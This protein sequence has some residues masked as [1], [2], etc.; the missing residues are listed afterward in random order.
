MKF[1][2]KKT[3]YLSLALLILVLV[4]FYILPSVQKYH[5]RIYVNEEPS[6]Q[7]SK[8]IRTCNSFSPNFDC[9]RNYPENQIT[10]K[11]IKAVAY[12]NGFELSDSGWELIE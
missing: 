9:I 8:L 7:G 6:D 1:D 5:I 12:D 11:Y 4:T 10:G 2:S 3:L